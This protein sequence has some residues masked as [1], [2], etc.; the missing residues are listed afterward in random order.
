[1]YTLIYFWQVCVSIY[2]SYISVS[3]SISLAVT[4]PHGQLASLLLQY[5]LNSIDAIGQLLILQKISVFFFYYIILFDR[6][7]FSPKE[8][9]TVKQE[10]F[11]AWKN[12]EFVP[13][14]VLRQENFANFIG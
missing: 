13:S 10:K 3:K 7:E 6:I 14:R 8:T 5:T 1:M 2:I 9:I 11:T 4:G 12:F